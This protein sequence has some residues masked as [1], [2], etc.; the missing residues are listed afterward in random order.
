MKKRR[1]TLIELLVVIAIIAILAAMLLPALQQAKVRAN[2]TRC[3]NNL[4]QCGV[5][6]QTYLDDHRDWWPA[7]NRNKTIKIKEANLPELEA[8]IYTW[9]LYK[10][11]YVSLGVA[12][13]EKPSPGVFHCPGM[14]LKSGD[15]SGAKYP[16]V[17][18]TQYNHNHTNTEA[19]G[20]AGGSWGLGYSVALP[21][22]NKG[23]R[24]YNANAALD[25]ISPSQRVLLCD[26]LNTVERGAM[27]G[28]L[29]AFE[30][31]DRIHENSTDLGKP[32]FLHGGRTNLLTVAGNVVNVDVDTFRSDYYFPFFGYGTPVCSR[33]QAVYLDTGEYYYEK[34]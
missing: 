1:F 25:Q 28:H 10:G 20:M 2:S 7:G 26:N 22:W 34:N 33:A 13:T 6:A 23:R 24:T 11:K 4:K 31:S 32:Y 15:P 5:V 16:Q 9:N 12:D 30:G 14:D 8:N 19:L 3:V 18:A 17:Y 27:V 29:Y 21:G